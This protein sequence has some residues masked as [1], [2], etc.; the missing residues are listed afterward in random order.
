MQKAVEMLVGELPAIRSEGGQRE[1]RRR[2]CRIIV[3]IKSAA[4]HLDGKAA[5]VRQTSG[6]RG[7]GEK[8]GGPILRQPERLESPII[9][10]KIVGR[11]LQQIPTGIHIDRPRDTSH[12]HVVGREDFTSLERCNQL[13]AFVSQLYS[14]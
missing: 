11:P 6:S 4:T 7:I 14:T 12:G 2:R 8:Q 5:P 13:H 10:S 1:F 3:R 9:W